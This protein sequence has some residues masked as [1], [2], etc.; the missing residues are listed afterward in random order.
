MP[1]IDELRVLSS[2]HYF[3]GRVALHAILRAMGIGRGDEVIVPGLTCLAVPLPVLS[4]GAT[5]I[6]ADISTESYNMDLRALPDLVTGKT[7]AIILQHTY[8]I[9]VD[10]DSVVRWAHQRGIYVIE[11]CCHTLMSKWNG[12]RVGT[13]GDAAFYSYEWGKPVILGGGGTALANEVVLQ[14]E[15]ERLYTR[16]MPAPLV[17]SLLLWLQEKAF[18]VIMRPSMFWPSRAVFRLL[19]FFHLV[20]PTFSRQ[21]KRASLAHGDTRMPSF[22]VKKLGGKLEDLSA[23][24]RSRRQVAQ[25]YEEGLRGFGIPSGQE[26]SAQ[27]IVYLRYPLLVRDKNR[28]LQRAR[29]RLIEVGDWFIS[30]IHPLRENE[31]NRV[32]YRRGMCPTAEA[33][34]RQVITL[35]V[36]RKVRPAHVRRTLRFLGEIRKEGLL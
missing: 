26:D 14:S 7:R 29:H 35:P 31:W 27:D 22:L 13:M 2:F 19:S 33:V 16:A 30:P 8:G 18:Q 9:P 20:V 4:L 1:D 28:V 6:Y 11:D 3:K 34:S 15:I 21:E 32:S 17:P 36:Y 12:K 5:P 25:Q 23:D 10:V 24:A